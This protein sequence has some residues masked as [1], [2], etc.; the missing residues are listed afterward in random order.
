MVH[1]LILVV[2]A[3]FLAWSSNANHYE[4]SGTNH[5]EELSSGKLLEDITDRLAKML[6]LKGEHVNRRDQKQLISSRV[7]HFTAYHLYF[8]SA[9]NQQLVC[10][11]FDNTNETLQALE[12]NL[13]NCPNLSYYPRKILRSYISWK[14]STN[15]TSNKNNTSSST[16]SSNENSMGNASG[17]NDSS[18]LSPSDKSSAKKEPPERIHD[19]LILALLMPNHPFSDEFRAALSVVGPMFPQVTIITGNAYE[20]KDIANKYF[21]GDFPRAFFFKNGLFHRDIDLRDPAKLAAYVAAWTRSYP[22]SLPG[23]YRLIPSQHPPSYTYL[24]AP[25]FL[26]DMQKILDHIPLPY[27]NLEPFFGST[28]YHQKFDVIAFIFAT[29]FTICRVLYYLYCKL[30]VPVRREHEQ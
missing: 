7:E 18:D 1:N 25:L 21:V 28:Q 4:T 16:N 24:Q 9:L 15:S 14:S 8:Q 13:N 10:L 29:I 2:L 27:P 5:S 11:P 19:Y 3:L 20:F 6:P 26:G 23:K 12:S 22:R 30:I 17:K